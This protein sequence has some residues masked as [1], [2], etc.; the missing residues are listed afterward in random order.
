MSIG[1]D[2]LQQIIC[3]I[4]IKRVP[5]RYYN[6]DF[7]QIVIKISKIKNIKTIDRERY[8]SEDDHVLLRENLNGFRIMRPRYEQVPVWKT[9][10]KSRKEMK[11]GYNK[12]LYNQLN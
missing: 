7:R 6:I 8:E 2:V 10:G 4:E 12:N 1:A 5:R 11:C 3:P 9:S